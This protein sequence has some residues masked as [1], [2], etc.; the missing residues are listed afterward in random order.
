MT[1]QVCICGILFTCLKHRLRLVEWDFKPVIQPYIVEIILPICPAWR[2]AIFKVKPLC[3][4]MQAFIDVQLRWN[5]TSSTDCNQASLGSVYS[6]VL[7]IVDYASRWEGLKLRKA[8]APKICG[9]VVSFFSVGL[10]VMAKYKIA[11]LFKLLRDWKNFCSIC[12]LDWVKGIGRT[13]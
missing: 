10:I 3:T 5:N 9:D 4:W 13:G 11:T 7:P 12:A 2:L 1:R 8:S 6:G